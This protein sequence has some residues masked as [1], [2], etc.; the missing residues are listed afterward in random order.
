[1]FKTNNRKVVGIY[2][3]ECGEWEETTKALFLGSY[4][5]ATKICKMCKAEVFVRVGFEENLND[6]LCALVLGEDEVEH[7][8]K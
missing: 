2:F 1:M 4:I 5:R 6:M 8:R 3:C 7:C